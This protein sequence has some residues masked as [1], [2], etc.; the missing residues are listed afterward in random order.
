MKPGYNDIALYDTSSIA[1]DIL[2]Y[3]LVLL[4]NR[5]VTLL[6]YNTRL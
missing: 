6:D 2:W 5:N 4:L 3:Q 1:T